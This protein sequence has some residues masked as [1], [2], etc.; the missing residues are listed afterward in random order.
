M[1]E[2][3]PEQLRFPPISGFSIRGD[4]QGGALSS[5]FGPILLRGVDQQ[6]GLIDRLAGA[7]NDRRHLSYIDHPLPDLLA[8]RIFQVACGYE[9]GNDAN[10]LRQDPMFKLAVERKPLDADEHLASGPTF[11]RLENAVTPQ[12]MYRMAQAFV[13]QFIQSY[14]EAP[15]IIVLD[16]DHSEDPTHGQQELALYNHHYRNHCYL[17]LFIFEGLSGELITAALRPGKRPSGAENASILKRVIKHLRRHWPHTHIVLR[18]DGHFANPELMRLILNDPHSDFI[19]GL[20]SNAV[21][22][23]LA[24]PVLKSTRE[25]HQLRCE[26]ASRSDSSPPHSTKTY[27]EFNYGAESWLQPFR[28]ILKAEV[29]SLGDNPRFVVTTLKSPTPEIL[30]KQLYCARG[31]DEN[32]IKMIK[33]DLASDRTSDQSFLANQLRL[34]FACGAYVLHHALRTQTL[35]HTELAN[36]QPATVIVKLFKLA[37][38]VVQYKDRIKLHLPSGCAVKS[39]L[40]RV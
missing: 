22:A 27:H 10:C 26:N 21:L 4:F 9:D 15:P 31:Q 1:L 29:M 18:G 30:Y 19:F 6:I 35:I 20:P 16:M 23:R 36:A 14:S 2:S 39:L 3:T 11:S 32:Y 25:R 7:I 33:N 40:S 8:Q 28:V 5:D 13:D 12:D 17:P 38:R 37:V 34:F 24:Q